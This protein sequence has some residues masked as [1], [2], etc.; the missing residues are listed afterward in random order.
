MATPYQVINRLNE[1]LDERVLEAIYRAKKPLAGKPRTGSAVSAEGDYA[2]FSID[3]V[4]AGRPENVPLAERDQRKESLSGQSGI[5]D[6]TAF[7]LQLE[8]EADIV[9]SDDAL[10]EQDGFQ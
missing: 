2:V 6:Y 9:R 10:A 3:A 5:A 8:S 4:A 1:E 7:I